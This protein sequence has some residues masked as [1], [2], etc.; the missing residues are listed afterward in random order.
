M[1]C[2][3]KRVMPAM[4]ARL[5]AEP[6]VKTVF[7][8]MAF[9]VFTS[10]SPASADRLKDALLYAYEHNPVLAAA[11]ADVAVSSEDVLEAE[12]P[13]RPR[14][15]LATTE[16]EFLK[17]SAPSSLL[18]DRTLRSD[19]TVSIP[20]YRSGVV[21]YSARDA[22]KR[23]AA[24]RE[25]LRA[26]TSEVFGAVA[27]AYSDVLREM[28]IVR[29]TE[30]NVTALEANLRATRGRFS[31]GDLTITDVALSQARL[32]LAEGDLRAA[33]AR[34]IASREE[35]VRVVG[36]PPGDISQVDYQSW[37]GLPRGPQ[38][39]ITEAV[40]GNGRLLASRLRVEAAEYRI[41]SAEGERGLRVSA[42]GTGGYFNNLDSIAN[43]SIFR[44]R[45]K[46]TA[47]Q[48][49]FALEL[50]LYQ[51][52]LPASRVRRARAERGSA[53]EEVIAAERDLVAQAR[54]AYANWRF[55]L[56]SVAKVQDAVAANQQALKGARSEN[57]VGTRTLLDV[58]NTERELLNSQVT[59]AAV[60]R[61][62]N[63]AAFALLALMG[64]ADPDDLGLTNNVARLVKPRMSWSDWADGS[65]NPQTLST[66]TTDTRPQDGI[67]DPVSLDH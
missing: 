35:F 51:A 24:A 16:T 4:S 6:F 14:A 11:N 56:E 5:T 55:A 2:N 58:L 67:V 27:V 33:R 45:D 46:G 57:A 64:K 31:I 43:R 40:A 21:K 8:T 19:V 38:E 20:L 63:V 25:D 44:P 48:V 54:S 13:G 47:V 62:A 34:L 7:R 9:M 66:S 39:A 30:R 37:P 49:G 65:V 36:V 15:S 53:F 61:D 42:F 29:A 26:I 52:G 17:Q 1:D 22:R 59:L 60:Q 10:A 32:S 50:P 3:A 41:R 23:F 18:P 12:A 28:A